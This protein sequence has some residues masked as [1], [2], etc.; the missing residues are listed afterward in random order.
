MKES[1]CSASI[2]HGLFHEI[3][4][5]A[6]ILHPEHPEHMKKWQLNYQSKMN[7]KSRTFY[8]WTKQSEINCGQK[9]NAF[10]N[11]AQHINLGSLTHNGS[12]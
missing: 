10:D 8:L 2:T 12:I 5:T 4:F 7:Q 3:N 11:N 6:W 1:Y 9:V